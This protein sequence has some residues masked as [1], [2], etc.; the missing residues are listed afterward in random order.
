[1][2]L[3]IAAAM[4]GT[5]AAIGMGAYRDALD[6][7]R[8]ARAIADIQTLEREIALYQADHGHLPDTLADLGRENLRDPWGNPYEYLKF[9][10]LL[11]PISA[12]ESILDA[13]LTDVTMRLDQF[14]V[15]LNSTY[16]LYSKGKDGKTKALLTAEES[17][18]DIV[19]A[20]DGGYIG[21][22]SEY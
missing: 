8:I 19:R 17:W 3:L 1:V 15:P 2:E 7:A 21:L 16:D 14:L 11:E 4:L 18:D 5:L 13:P 6:K 9:S 20:N 10:T 12:V 22:A